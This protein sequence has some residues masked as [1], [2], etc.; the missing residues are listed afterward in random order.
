MIQF[1]SRKVGRSDRPVVALLLALGLALV[2]WG[3]APAPARVEAA[4]GLQDLLAAC[5]LPGW[6]PD[7]GVKEGNVFLHDGL[8]YYVSTY[9]A[10]GSSEDPNYEK[11][12][13]YASSPNLCSWTDLGLILPVSAPDRPDE[14]DNWRIWTP[15]VYQED[16]TYYMY[17]TG[18]RE[19]TEAPVMGMV[20]SI[21]LATSTDP[22]DPASWQRQGMIFQPSHP[23]SYYPGCTYWCDCRDPHVFKEDGAY[24]M[25]YS[26]GDDVGGIVGLATAAS[27]YGP[28]IDLGAMT[29]SEISMP[30]NAALVERNG[31]YYLFYNDSHPPGLGEVYRIGGS[32]AGPWSQPSLFSPG[33]AHEFFVGYDG[34]QYVA[35]VTSYELEIRRLSWID[36][37]F[38]PQPWIPGVQAYTLWLPVVGR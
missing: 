9:L 13:A 21:M 5:P 14:W 30:E 7:Y 27:P 36:L 24:Y 32:S 4:A 16:G 29:T 8:Y 10:Q 37:V 38:P 33:W 35:Y 25:Y 22:A 20:Q 28:W 12:F 34:Q 23:G 17:Y 31:L 26:G 2:C 11:W 15:H 19:E 1:F 6:H 3:G 18:V